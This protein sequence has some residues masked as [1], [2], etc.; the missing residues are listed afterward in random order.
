MNIYI[1]MSHDFCKLSRFGI[2]GTDD[3]AQDVTE[4]DL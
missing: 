1:Y 2:Q 4:Q 3:V